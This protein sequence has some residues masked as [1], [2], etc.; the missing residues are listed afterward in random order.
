LVLWEEV[1]GGNTDL[2]SCGPPQ[3][4]KNSANRFSLYT[5]AVY[6]GSAIYTPSEPYVEEKFGVSPT[7]ASLGLALYVLGCKLNVRV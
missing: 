5:L 2:V 3:S 6:L 7:A 1:R 4:P